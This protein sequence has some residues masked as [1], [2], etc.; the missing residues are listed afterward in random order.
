MAARG[1]GARSGRSL[2]DVEAGSFASREKL[3]YQVKVTNGDGDWAVE[4]E[5]YY[6]VD[7]GRI[8]WLRVLCSGYC[9]LA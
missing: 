7:G 2:D 1:A 8:D 9:R 6:T 4:Q 3:R 5:A